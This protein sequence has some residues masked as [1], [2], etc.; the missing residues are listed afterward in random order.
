MVAN[1]LAVSALALAALAVVSGFVTFLSIATE[2][3]FDPFQY[4]LVVLP[5]LSVT[6]GI[7][8]LG[9]KTR[10]RALAGVAIGMGIVVFLIPAVFFV[11]ALIASTQGQ[12]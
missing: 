5:L 6:A 4:G 11:M 9:L 2:G 3:V 7:V 8:A 12:G 1:W 10:R